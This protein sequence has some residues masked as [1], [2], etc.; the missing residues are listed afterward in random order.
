MKPSPAPSPRLGF[1]ERCLSLWVAARMILELV[2]GSPVNFPIAVPIW[3]TTT[4]MMM[5][6]NF[7]SIRDVG[8]RPAGLFVTLF[9]N[10]V[11]KLFS[12]AF[13]AWLFFRHVFGGLIAAAEAD[14]YIAGCILLAAAP[15]AAIWLETRFLPRLAPVAISALLAALVLTFAFQSANIAGR[16]FHVPLIAVVSAIALFGR[17]PRA[18]IATVAGVLAGVPI[19]LSVRSACNRAR[20]W[21]PAPSSAPELCPVEES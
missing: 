3:L 9:V 2:P 11:V 12:M 13:P 7:R 16:A 8:K 19:V 10:W 17:G 15:Y 5:R 6:V 14:R 21:F 4:P 20:G 1:Y 18:A